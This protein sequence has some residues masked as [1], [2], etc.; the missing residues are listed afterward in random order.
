MRRVSRKRFSEEWWQLKTTGDDSG[1]GEVFVEFFPAEG[2]AVEF[3]LHAGELFVAG[4]EED[5]RAVCGEANDAAIVEFQIDGAV[6]SPDAE[7]DGFGDLDRGSECRRH[8]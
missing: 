4:L 3:D 5:A 8:F 1:Y 6:L 2:G 7:G